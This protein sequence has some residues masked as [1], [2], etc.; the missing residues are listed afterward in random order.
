MK[1]RYLILNILL[2]SVFAQ[3]KATGYY[4]Y[5]QFKNKDN[6]SYSLSNP[7]AY[8]TQRA[9]NRRAYFNVPIDST[10][11]PVNQG[12]VS[13]I[14]SLNATVHSKTKWLN[15]VTVILTDSSKINDI[16]NLSFVK[17]VQFTG[18]TNISGVLVP[19]QKFPKETLST[20]YGYGATQINQLNGSVLHDN[21]Y[22]GQG[23]L[24]AVIDG[25]YNSA[26]TNPGFDSLRN[27][28]R[29]LGVKN[30]V[31]PNVS[32]YTEATHGNNVLSLW[33]ETFQT[34]M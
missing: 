14:Q 28:G 20:N 31:G 22:R 3:L 5:V 19:R 2:C 21:G 9:L 30:L 34:L 25:G 8:L 16:K 15:G 6:T 26:N 4:F 13:Q 27:E 17:F 10:D 12:Y 32:V 33:R 1:Y 18:K 24:I 23:M 29:L 7:S 11:L